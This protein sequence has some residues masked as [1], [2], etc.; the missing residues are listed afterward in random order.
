MKSRL[1]KFLALMMVVSMLFAQMSVQPAKANPAQAPAAAATTPVKYTLTVS[2]TGIYIVR[3]QDAS[4]AA[5]QGGVAG[6]EATSPE[7]TGARRL[8]TSTPQSQAYLSYLD[9]KQSELLSK[10]EAAFGHPVEVVFQ[11]KNVLNAVAVRISHAEALQAFDLAGVS[12]VYPDTL[13]ELETDIGPTLIGA[14]S[15][16]NGNTG[17]GVATFGEEIIIGMIDSGINHAHPSFADIGGDGYDH[18][19]PYG[20]GNYVG[21]CDTDDPTFCNDK[22]IGAYGLNPVGGDP[23]D[24]DGHGSHTASTSGGNFVDVGID[25]GA[26][27]TFTVTI[28]RASPRMPTSLPTR[29]AT[30]AALARPALRRLT[31]RLKMVCMS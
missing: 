13:R 15:I 26:G 30:R 3:L 16:W 27:G 23:E 22:L 31:W 7:A 24:T 20:A 4:L 29:S 28:S 6:L 12:A 17:G 11:Y 19:N 8:D 5:Y 1:F 25:D 10:M 18:T 21:W 14:P 2:E 9:G